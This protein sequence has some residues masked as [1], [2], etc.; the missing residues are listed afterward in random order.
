[1]IALLLCYLHG[2]IEKDTLSRMIVKGKIK[3]WILMSHGF[4]IK[5]GMTRDN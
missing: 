4:A 3:A 2:L 5:Q 1:M